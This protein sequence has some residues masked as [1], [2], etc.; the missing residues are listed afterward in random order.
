MR[1]LVA[2][3]VFVM[4]GPMIA[5]LMILPLTDPASPFEVKEL[6]GY[7]AAAGFLIALPISYIIAWAIMR[8]VRRPT[9]D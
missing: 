4:V 1:F 8:R 9:T 6:F 5:G 3:L 2:L 7:V